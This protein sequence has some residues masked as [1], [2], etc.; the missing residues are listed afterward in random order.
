MSAIVGTCVYGMYVLVLYEQ[1]TF[2]ECM[3]AVGI[4]GELG[5]LECCISRGFDVK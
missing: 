1:L 4:A 2:R 5:F 3:S